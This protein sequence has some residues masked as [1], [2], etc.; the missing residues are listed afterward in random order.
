MVNLK[1]IV[2]LLLAVMLVVGVLAAC[3]NS[4]TTSAPDGTGSGEAGA[5]A[6]VT[7]PVTIEYWHNHGG[8]LGKWMTEKVKEFNETNGT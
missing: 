4:S 5:P 8:D 7:G 1:K 3:D 2:A 6:Q